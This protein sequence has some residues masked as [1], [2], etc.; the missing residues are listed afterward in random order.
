MIITKNGIHVDIG[1]NSKLIVKKREAGDV[2]FTIKNNIR[3]NIPVA[4]EISDEVKTELLEMITIL[5]D[6]LLPIRE[7]AESVFGKEYVTYE[8]PETVFRKESPHRCFD[9]T[10]TINV[11]IPELTVENEYGAN[12][13]IRNLAMRTSILNY[14]KDSIT[15]SHVFGMRYT[16]SF[17]EKLKD[18]GH[19]HLRGTPGI[20]DTFC[21]GRSELSACINLSLPY[22]SIDYFFSLM[23]SLAETESISGTPYR[24]LSETIDVRQALNCI[25]AGNRRITLPTVTNTSVALT[26]RAAVADGTQFPLD[27]TQIGD[28]GGNIVLNDGAVDELKAILIKYAPNSLKISNVENDSNIMNEANIR[29]NLGIGTSLALINSSSESFMFNGTTYNKQEICADEEES[30]LISVED[31][32]SSKS[33]VESKLVLEDATL[34]ALLTKVKIVINNRL[35]YEPRWSI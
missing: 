31:N 9:R 3:Y 28:N 25:I 35:E 32:K 15:F 1:I 10:F 6:M 14:R 23:R 20:F 29:R 5:E 4:E 13:K 8:I 12:T 16:L 30:K 17:R 18:Y 19:S 7:G 21:L 26:I 34:C 2:T 27:I 11:L 33:K 22:T 24:H